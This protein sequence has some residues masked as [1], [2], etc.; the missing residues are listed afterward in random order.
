M[1]NTDLQNFINMLSHAK[2]PYGYDS[3]FGEIEITIY[4]ADANMVYIFSITTK[5]LVKVFVQVYK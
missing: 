2:Q 4:G 5:A 3:R 1:D